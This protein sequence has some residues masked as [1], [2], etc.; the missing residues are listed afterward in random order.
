L[1]F[2]CINK[3][4]AGKWAGL[5]GICIPCCKTL[6]EQLSTS[7]TGGSGNSSSLR[8]NQSQ[9]GNSASSASSI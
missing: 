9:S 7:T 3:K 4:V 2:Y 8:T 6:E 5:F 1:F